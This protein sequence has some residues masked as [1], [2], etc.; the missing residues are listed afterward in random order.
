LSTERWRNRLREPDYQSIGWN[1]QCIELDQS[2]EGLVR[3][4]KPEHIEYR[5]IIVII[6]LH[7]ETE[8]KDRSSRDIW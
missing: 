4:N 2:V 5:L 3:E 8:Q 6:Q 7:K 1:N